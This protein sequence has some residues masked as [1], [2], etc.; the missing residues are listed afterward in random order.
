MN[1]NNEDKCSIGLLKKGKNEKPKEFDGRYSKS[2]TKKVTFFST[3][4]KS[5]NLL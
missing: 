5:S 1:S 4:Q 3:D 2:S